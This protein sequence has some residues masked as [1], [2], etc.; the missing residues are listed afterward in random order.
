[1][2]LTI[3]KNDYLTIKALFHACADDD[4]RIVLTRVYYD[5]NLKLLIAC[6]GHLA[7]FEKPETEFI[8][9]HYFEKSE[10]LKSEKMLK[11][12][13]TVQTFE[14]E[15]P[16]Y[17]KITNVIPLIEKIGDL[18][19]LKMICL[20][21]EL[22]KLLEKSI[23]KTKKE[24]TLVFGFSSQLGATLVFKGLD[25]G[26]EGTILDRFIGVIMPFK[27]LN[28]TINDEIPLPNL[29][30]LVRTDIK[31]ISDKIEFE[32]KKGKVF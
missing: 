18:K 9:N 5:H 6:S 11:P 19:S 1:M 25:N 29:K 32:M 20:N 17:P 30:N 27:I 12:T 22:I 13:E 8:E 21:I 28:V 4:S 7:R 14:E 2:I 31:S 3:T 10:F 24:T 15:F 26:I 23:V 16:S